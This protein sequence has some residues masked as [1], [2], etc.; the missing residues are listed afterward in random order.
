MTM[1]S[2]SHRQGPAPWRRGSRC[3]PEYEPQQ[4]SVVT[5]PVASSVLL[6]FA[7]SYPHPARGT[8]SLAR[9][10]LFIYMIVQEPVPI[11]WYDPCGNMPIVAYWPLTIS[12]R[13]R[14]AAIGAGMPNWYRA[15][16][17]LL[18]RMD[19]IE[20]RFH[21]LPVDY[22]NGHIKYSIPPD[23]VNYISSDYEYG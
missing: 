4:P 16:P 23:T 13:I 11:F 18:N 20:T 15:S 19:G 6:E 1:K 10:T 8:K 12:R 5:M 17:D 9:Q 22:Y 14:P 7:F 2:H 3:Q 21:L